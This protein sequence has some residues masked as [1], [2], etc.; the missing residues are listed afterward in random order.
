VNRHSRG[1]SSI[2]AGSK[3]GTKGR[4]RSFAW[5]HLALRLVWNIVWTLFAS[6]T[7]PQ[8]YTWRRFLLNLF[9]ADIAKGARVYGSATIWYPPNLKMGTGSVLGWQSLAYTQ[10]KIVIEEHAI[11]SQ[12]ARLITGT[13]DIDDENFQLYT[14][15]IHIK[16]H[17]WVAAAAFVGPGVTI[18]EGAVL[19]GAAV[20]F[21]DLEPW[22]V[23]AGNPAKRIKERKRFLTPS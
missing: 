3:Y 18:G 16:A 23:Y 4:E 5:S 9:G 13:H 14:K 7:P 20:T 8:F 12:F 19:G 1:D 6:W 15:P 22:T 11:V 10:D 2:L 21:K 17:G